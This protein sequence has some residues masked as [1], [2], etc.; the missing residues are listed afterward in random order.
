MKRLLAPTAFKLREKA[1]VFLA[2][3]HPAPDAAARTGAL[4]RLRK[5]DHDATHHCSAWREGLPVKVWG[6]DDD[7]EPGGTAGAPM[8]RVLEGADLTDLIAV[9]IRWYG[10]TKL[11]T[12]G[13]VRAYTEA[14]QGAI[15]E[16]ARGS[17]LEEVR[18]MHIGRLRV[19]Q[20]QAHLPFAFLR[21]IQG[22]E[23]LGQGSEGAAAWVRFQIPP[24]G[25]AALEA[26]WKERSRGLPVDWEP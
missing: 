7:G 5:R 22:T 13:L 8:L 16:A 21:G 12:G 14:V 11:G 17:L 10:G 9:C 2:E 23:V 6:A 20:V 26:A 18:A 25:E 19:P 3:L 24:G 1:S 15:A 4:A